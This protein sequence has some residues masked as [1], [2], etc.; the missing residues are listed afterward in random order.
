[1]INCTISGNTGHGVECRY[2]SVTLTNCILSENARAGVSGV[3]LGTP[4]LTNCTIS[5][6]AY[7]GVICSDGVPCME[8]GGAT[9]TNCILW[10]D[11]PQEVLVQ[12]GCED[13][14]HGEPEM[15]YCDVQGGYAGTG[16]ID[17]DP[18]FV[19]PAAG[20]YHLGAGSPCIDAGN[21]AA[22]PAGVLTDLDGHPR[23]VDDPNT[24]DTGSGTPPIVDLGAY[25]F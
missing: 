11:T 15:T 14:W 24:P 8:F 18:R 10:G 9:L 17:A 23:F 2:G 3:G 22:V 16:N 4:R 6:N 1:L 13:P 19:D 12:P 7:Y 25:E 5:G 20:D 21:N